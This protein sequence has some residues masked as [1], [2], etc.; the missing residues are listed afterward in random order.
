METKDMIKVFNERGHYAR[1]VG[2]EVLGVPDI[3]ACVSGWFVAIEN[4]RTG[5]RVSPLQEAH[6]IQILYDNGVALVDP[7]ESDL[8]ETLKFLEENPGGRVRQTMASVPSKESVPRVL[9]QMCKSEY[10]SRLEV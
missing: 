7:E 5:D 9:W 8:M 10:G 4:K 1:E 3:L 6:R 2:C